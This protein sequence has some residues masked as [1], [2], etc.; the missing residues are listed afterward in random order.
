MTNEENWLSMRG[1][2]MNSFFIPPNWE[3]WVSY[4]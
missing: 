3:G 2:N 4:R 1:E